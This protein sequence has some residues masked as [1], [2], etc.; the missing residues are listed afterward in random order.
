MWRW[1]ERTR[2]GTCV[3]GMVARALRAFV[4]HVLEEA[5]L[6]RNTLEE[7]ELVEIAKGKATQLAN[8]LE[9]EVK[10]KLI[11]CLRKNSDI[12]AKDVHDLMGIHL[13]SIT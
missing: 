3:G 4:V 6:K 9:P 2:R 11:A 7:G 1:S 10:G 13:R 8:E 5:T 12:V